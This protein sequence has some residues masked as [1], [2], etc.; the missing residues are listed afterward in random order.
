MTRTWCMKGTVRHEESDMYK[1]MVN[2]GDMED[3][4]NGIC[5]RLEIVG[6]ACVLN[7]HTINWKALRILRLKY[8]GFF[9]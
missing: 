9:I 5:F 6:N 3:C 2:E 7:S 4:L 8:L 1:K